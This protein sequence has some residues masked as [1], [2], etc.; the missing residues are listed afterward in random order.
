MANKKK[1]T[2]RI[3][4]V[5][6]VIIFI[7]LSNI[8]SMFMNIIVFGIGMSYK[9]ETYDGKYSMEYLPAKGGKM[10]II[11]SDFKD[12]IEHNPE[13]KGTKYY[14]TFKR[15]PLVFWNW[16]KY[17]FGEQYKVEY[18]KPSGFSRSIRFIGE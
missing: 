3:I 15:N 13:Y 7:V 11:D 8:F 14:R 9:F 18:K 5:S 1:K 16:Y 10:Y 2:R 17:I 4:T 6:A 12:L